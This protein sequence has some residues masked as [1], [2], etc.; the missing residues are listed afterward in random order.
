MQS[1]HRLP[2]G[3]CCRPLVALAPQVRVMLICG[4]FAMRLGVREEGEYMDS[5]SKAEKPTPQERIESQPQPPNGS[6]VGAMARPTAPTTVTLRP[7]STVPRDR[8]FSLAAT[9]SVSRRIG[10]T[11]TP[12]HQETLS[13]TPGAPG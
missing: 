8:D 4:G 5:L 11:G 7:S 6:W 9:P 12:P 13:V 2:G 1:E 10:A 3:W